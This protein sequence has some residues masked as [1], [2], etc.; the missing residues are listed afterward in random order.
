[1]F[2]EKS[3]KKKKT[4][5]T[6]TFHCCHLF[7]HHSFIYIVSDKTL[8]WSQTLLNA[9]IKCIKY[10]LLYCNLKALLKW[11]TVE[12]L[13]FVVTQFLWYSLVALLHEVKS[14]RKTILLE[15]FFL[16]LK[17]DAFAKLHLHEK[18]KSNNQLKLAPTN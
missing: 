7:K 10:P 3:K 11:N 17:F 15:C 6:F 2:P 8:F 12:S 9:F 1:M 16:V 13:Q 18:Q 14:S 4:R 5:Y